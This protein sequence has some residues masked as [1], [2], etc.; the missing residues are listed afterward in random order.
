MTK[1][2][3]YPCVNTKTPEPAKEQPPTEQHSCYTKTETS[4]G[5]LP[6]TRMHQATL[7]APQQP[8]PTTLTRYKPFYYKIIGYIP[9]HILR[10]TEREP[11]IV[12]KVTNPFINNRKIYNHT[13]S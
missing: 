1:P 8:K 12:C 7:T 9:R 6:H 4:T 13:L 2:H 11:T 5:P 3:A 10:N